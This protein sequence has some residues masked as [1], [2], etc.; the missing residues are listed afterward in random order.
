MR[1][2]RFILSGAATLGLL[3]A[4][5]VGTAFA[6][7]WPQWRGPDRSGVSRD[8]GLLK[9]WPA[10]GPK[11]LWTARGLGEGHTSPA[12]ANGRVIGMGLRGGDEVVWAVDEKTGKEVW[13][14]RIAAVTE[15]EARQGG[16]GPRAT[17]TVDGGSIY[18]LGVGG[19]LVCLNAADGKMRWQK[20]LVTDFGGEVPRWGY[21][22]SPLVEGDKVIAA[23]GGAQNTVVA[24]NKKDGTVA[25][26]CAVPGGDD[27]HYASAIAADVSGQR[28]VIHFL[29]GGVLGI[30]AADGKF[31]WR[32]ASPANRTANCS[33]PLYRDGHVFAASGYQTGGALAKLT[34]GA[35]GATAAQEVYFTRQMQNHHGGMVLVGD[36]L[37]GFDNSNLTCLEFRTGKLMWSDRSVGK[38]S[39]SAADG[40]L[41][42]RSERGPMA[43]VEANPKAYVEKGR[44]EQPERSRAASWA[45]PVI[46]NGRLYLHD[47]D[48][49]L[50]YDLKGT[51]AGGTAKVARR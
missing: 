10:E 26:K 18:A 37:Y 32:F 41:Y 12:V 33:T 14:A 17:P 2:S 49:L 31:L 34:R 13:S 50:C 51:A 24:L 28:Q 8:T 21:S 45:Y 11:L 40:L 6:G 47:Q 7:D 20:S 46:A 15:L 5:L 16:F 27:A 39:V 22:E 9:A 48:V 25:W 43:L 29:S 44:F 1:A 38:G 35:G 30:G 19:S 3:G 4:I 42:V 36:Y 23:P